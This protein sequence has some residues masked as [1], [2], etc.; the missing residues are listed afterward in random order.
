MNIRIIWRAPVIYLQLKWGNTKRPSYSW[1][2]GLWCS[3]SKCVQ[4]RAEGQ[5][6]RCPTGATGRRRGI[7]QWPK[8]RKTGAP[9]C[10]AYRHPSTR[11]GEV[12]R[13]RLQRIIRTKWS[14]MRL[15]MYA[16]IMI[17]FTGD[18]VYSM[19]FTHAKVGNRFVLRSSQQRLTVFYVFQ[20][21]LVE[22]RHVLRASWESDSVTC[23]RVL[24]TWKDNTL[25]RS[26]FSSLLYNTLQ[27]MMLLNYY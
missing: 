27:K 5:P 14:A 19:S 8:A 4:D 11:S 6:D 17:S 10:T 23:H 16:F 7:V 21:F 2:G 20:Q 3:G 22:L 24:T 26:I 12:D 25:S 15:C 18:K 1:R 9:L 13:C